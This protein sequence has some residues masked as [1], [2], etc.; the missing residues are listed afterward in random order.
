MKRL[1]VIFSTLLFLVFT[2]CDTEQK[3]T[4]QTVIDADTV[5]VEKKYEIEKTIK[6]KTVEVDTITETETVTQEE[7]YESEGGTGNNY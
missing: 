3:Q 7:E 4:E 5:S 6:E 2:S 1:I